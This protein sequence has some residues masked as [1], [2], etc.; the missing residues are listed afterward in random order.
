[1]K[2]PNLLKFLE[3]NKSKNR[4]DLQKAYDITK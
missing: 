2:S 3:K 4:L 1:M